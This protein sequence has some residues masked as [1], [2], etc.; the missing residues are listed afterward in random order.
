MQKIFYII[1]KQS[2]NN[3]IV[4]NFLNILFLLHQIMFQNF[5]KNYNNDKNIQIKNIN[6]NT[7]ASTS[8]IQFMK[9]D[10]CLKLF[11]IDQLKF[12]MQVKK[13]EVESIFNNKA[14]IN[15]ILYF[16]ML[17]LNLIIKINIQIHM[18]IAE[19][20]QNKFIKICYKMLIIISIMTIY[21]NFF[22]LKKSTAEC[23]LK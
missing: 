5:F 3:I 21:Q 6:K 19:N 18:Q 1:I 7:K 23:L 8:A 11:S 10:S 15:C 14:E 12:S 9:Y 17:F 13:Q 4:I 16:I 2:V 20:H 22:V